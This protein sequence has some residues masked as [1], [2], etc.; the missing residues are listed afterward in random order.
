MRHDS[1]L[2]VQ[3]SLAEWP[4]MGALSSRLRWFLL[5]VLAVAP[6]HGA[7]AGAVLAAKTLRLP[8]A[9]LQQVKATVTPAPGGGLRLQFDAERAEVPALGW[10]RV[11]LH[12]DTVMQRNP[13]QRWSVDGA[14]A[15]KRAPGAAFA[16]AQVSLQLDPEANT[17]QVDL[18]QGS[19]Q[20]TTAVPL[21]QPTHAQIRLSRFPFGWLQGL[22]NTIDAGRATGG[23]IDAIVALE[24]D[25]RMVYANDAAGRLFDLPSGQALLEF[26]R[27][28]WSQGRR[29]EIELVPVARFTHVLQRP[30]VETG[31]PSLTVLLDG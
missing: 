3:Q 13:H 29:D 1:I 2:V 8:G 5:A 14:L 15:V 23:R 4:D 19:S 20:A 12:L 25:G 18:R 7:R 31:S 26:A 22:L 24:P 17:L 30:A 28:M 27:R 6:V 16:D 11:G 21:D 10:H 9:T